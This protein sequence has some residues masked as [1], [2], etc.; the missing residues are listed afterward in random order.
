MFRSPFPWLRG[1]SGCGNTTRILHLRIQSHDLFMIM[2]AAVAAVVVKLTTAVVVL[3]VGMV[4][5]GTGCSHQQF[6]NTSWDSA[7]YRAHIATLS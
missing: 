1:C 6:H 2:M 4:G 5:S 7:L 3:M